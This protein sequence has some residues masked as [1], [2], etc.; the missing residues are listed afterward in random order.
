[1]RRVGR[2]IVIVG[3]VVFLVAAVLGTAKTLAV[4]AAC[5][6]I[7]IGLPMWLVGALLARRSR[8]EDGAAD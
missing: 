7:F 1:M 2:T 8:R 3:V 6:A 4:L 5:A